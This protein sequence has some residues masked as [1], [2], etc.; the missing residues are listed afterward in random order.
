MN[1]LV[2]SDSHG[3]PE[4]I[5][6]VMKKQI[7]T[8]DVVIFLGD[9]L[10][11][12]DYCD[13]MGATVYRVRGNCDHFTLIGGKD[14]TDDLVFTLG[15]KKIMMTHGHK[16]GVK[17]TITP[18]LNRAAE[19]GV[20]IL[21]FGHT[22]SDFEMVISPDDDRYGLKLTKSLYVMNPG[23]IGSYSGT[24]GNIVIDRSGRVLLSHGKL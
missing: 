19:N 12:L 23:S 15:S 7:R 22:H 11:D 16:Y 17:S 1:I 8:P 21:L 18:L 10:R 20:D 13:L 5:S 2:F 24:W 4:N 14:V 9:G 6:E 3:H